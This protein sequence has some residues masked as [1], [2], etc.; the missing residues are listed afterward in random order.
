MG[1]Y[2]TN[3]S[4]Q[5]KYRVH[6]VMVNKIDSISKITIEGIC[7]WK[8]WINLVTK[9]IYTTCPAIYRLGTVLML[10]YMSCFAVYKNL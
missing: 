5:Y 8:R 6:V 7:I 2:C 1:R 4:L 9:L 3:Y 10:W